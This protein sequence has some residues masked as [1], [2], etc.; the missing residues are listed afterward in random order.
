MNLP[1]SLL[2]LH[3]SPEKI[4][5]VVLGNMTQFFKL[6]FTK[7]GGWV[8]AEHIENVALIVYNPFHSYVF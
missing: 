6:A 7:F 2:N 8:L 4:Y 1:T 5:K 3:P